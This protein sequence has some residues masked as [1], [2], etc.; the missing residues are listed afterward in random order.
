M[1]L[2]A[3]SDNSNALI[4]NKLLLPQLPPITNAAYIQALRKD[5]HLLLLTPK[6]TESPIEM[7]LGELLVFI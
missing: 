4:T 5:I 3:F 7:F 2:T 1:A 6:K